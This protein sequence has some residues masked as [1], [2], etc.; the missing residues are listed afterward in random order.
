[1]HQVYEMEDQF[2]PIYG[3]DSV[4]GANYVDNATIFPQQINMGATFNRDLAV[5]F[6]DITARDTRATGIPW[7]FTPILDLGMQPTWPRQWETFSEDP[8]LTA[9][10]GKHVIHGIQGFDNDLSNPTKIA[11][12]MKHFL[13]YGDSRSGHD[14]TPS[15]IPDRYLLEYHVP[16]FQAAVDAGIATAMASFGDINGD[17]VTASHHYLRD[18]LRG[19]MGFEGML[20]TDWAEIKN[21][22]GWHRVAKS[23]NDAVRMA[24]LQTSVDMSMVPLDLSFYE[25]LM[26]LVA[27]GI[28]SEARVDESAE[29]VMQ[30]KKDLGLLDDRYIRG[31][32]TVGD[33]ESRQQA[34][35]AIRESVTL[36]ENDG[37]LPLR[38]NQKILVAGPLAASVGLLV[39]GWGAAWQGAPDSAYR[40]GTTVLD[41][42]QEVAGTRGTDVAFERALQSPEADLDASDLEK[43]LA[44]A[45]S[46]DV[47]V[48]A[49]GESTYAE[50]PGDIDDL[51]LPSG[52]LALLR[53]LTASATPVVVVLVQGRPRT[54]DGAIG[55][56]NAVVN[57]YLPGP[58]GGKG[59][60]DVLFGLENPSG[61]LPF[62]YPAFPHNHHFYYH[63]ISSATSFRPQWEFGR[64][65][66]Y[67]SFEY[68]DVI[69]SPAVIAEGEEATA[70][71][72]VSNTGDASGKHSILLYISQD[73]R[74]VS[75]EVKML[76][77]FEKIFLEPG[78]SATVEFTITPKMLSFIGLDLER[79]T[80]EGMFTIYAG[81]VAAKLELSFDTAVPACMPSALS[82]GMENISTEWCDANCFDGAGLLAAACD[83]ESGFVLCECN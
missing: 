75:P 73:Y 2:A 44:E 43:V 40:Y 59:I 37:V 58:D 41:G 34:L 82:N 36:L 27:A 76:K 21:L 39:G 65:L 79:T 48:L 18:L 10:L 66:S 57:A 13:G 68:S 72:V 24:M 17:A 50:K 56:A 26:E 61:R 20:V 53:A 46:S 49:L 74:T 60:A 19:K 67:T 1:M 47:V 81:D 42:V 69:M 32:D 45:A 83:P 55:A 51:M 12:C 54:F 14:R 7:T 9:E 11:A 35:E 4:H 8:Y 71:V 62:T 77:D 6:G 64:G 25:E 52:Q 38:D 78:E 16:A 28:V 31:E 3:V 29:R 63:K 70:S 5:H 22:H 30:L 80:E 15:W 33:D 23:Q